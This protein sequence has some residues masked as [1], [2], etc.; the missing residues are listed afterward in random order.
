[1]RT[2]RPYITPLEGACSFL[3]AVGVQFPYLMPWISS[4]RLNRPVMRVMSAD[5]AGYRSI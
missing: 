2:C 1:M 3:D 5:E 4:L